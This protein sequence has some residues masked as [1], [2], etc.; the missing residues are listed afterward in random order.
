MEGT[1]ADLEDDLLPLAV[2]HTERPVY[3]RVLVDLY[4]NLSWPLIQQAAYGDPESASRAEEQLGAIGQRSLQPLLDALLDSDPEQQQAAIAMLGHLGNP[5]AAVPLLAY[6][7]GTAGPPPLRVRAL[8]AAGQVGDDR[9]VDELSGLLG[10]SADV[11]LREAAAFGLAHIATPRAIDALARHLGGP[12]LAVRAL[13]CIGMGRLRRES[14]VDSLVARLDGD[15]SPVVRAAAA[16]AL[17][18]MGTEQATAALVRTI[19]AAPTEARTAAVWALGASG[20]TEAAR[21]LAAALFDSEPQVRAA[22]AWALRRAGEGP[23]ARRGEAPY[24]RMAGGQLRIASYVQD[25]L[26]FRAEEGRA[27]L[28]LARAGREI[29]AALDG[30]LGGRGLLRTDRVVVALRALETAGPGVLRLSPLVRP[31]ELDDDDVATGMRSLEEIAVRR[32]AAL[33][34][35]SSPEVRGLAAATL[36]NAGGRAAAEAL[37]SLLE[38]QDEGARELGAEQL[39]RLGGREATEAVSPLLDSADAATAGR[40]ARVLGLIGDDGSLERLLAVAQQTDARSSV[41]VACIRALGPHLGGLEGARAALAAAS[42]D[43][44]PQ[45]R[46]AACEALPDPTALPAGACGSQRGP[47]APE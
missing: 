4:A 40:A 41:R 45:V 38:E 16:W 26:R 11:L 29:E 24:H 33:L 15:Q 36:A 21:D 34:R 47:A 1:V 32:G 9:V 12:L 17:G 19:R 10:S 27:A 3:R 25:L 42:A 35:H 39:A 44:D 5:S 28:A 37:A 22:A 30:A 7:N 23:V 46:A 8:L 43:A 2:A 13:A 14:D 6:A 18:H 31:E 20:G